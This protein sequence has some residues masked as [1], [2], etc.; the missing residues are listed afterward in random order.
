MNRKTLVIL[1]VLPLIVFGADQAFTAFRSDGGGKDKNKPKQEVIQQPSIEANSANGNESKKADKP[2]KAVKKMSMSELLREIKAEK[3]NSE[4][5]YYS[6]DY[7]EDLIWRGDKSIAKATRKW[8]DE[9]LKQTM[10]KIDPMTFD[11]SGS[12][13]RCSSGYY[14]N[15]LAGTDGEPTREGWMIMEEGCDDKPMGRFRYDQAM[16]K[17][18]VRVSEDAGYIPLKEYLRALK[19]IES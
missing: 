1:L 4:E 7:S 2:A 6:L 18:E 12:F 16:T 15:I 5:E 10:D 13:G 8:L 19:K 9:N 14:Y 17:I 11:L 3:P